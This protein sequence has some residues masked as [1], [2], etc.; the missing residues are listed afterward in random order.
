MP[1][2]SWENP[3]DFLQG[4]EFALQVEI[5]RAGA[6]VRSFLAIFDEPSADAQVG[7]YHHDTTTPTIFSTDA[8]VAG[9]T[10]GD[11][12]RLEG[13]RFDVLGSP[14]PDG[15]GWSRVRI[16]PQFGQGGR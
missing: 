2:P 15:T 7:D 16:G 14:A 1:A 3:A 13:R 5:W 11:E 8:N 12:L 4:D 6:L 10:R 9:I